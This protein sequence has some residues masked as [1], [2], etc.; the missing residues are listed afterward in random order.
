MNTLDNNFRTYEIR[1]FILSS[2]KRTH[3]IKG[4]SWGFL[5]KDVQKETEDFFKR[6]LN[7]SENE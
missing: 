2:Y 5:T 4:I 3:E 7:K 6:I 1:D